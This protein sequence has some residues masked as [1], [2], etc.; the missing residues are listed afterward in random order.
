MLRR[1]EYAAP[2][3]RARFALGLVAG[4][5]LSGDTLPA[6]GVSVLVGIDL[7]PEAHD[8]ALRDRPRAYTEY[9]V[10]D[11][12]EPGLVAGLVEERGLNAPA[13]AG[14]LSHIPVEAFD[15]G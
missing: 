3:S 5:G 6:G 11:V 8:A 15:A 7:I 9:V 12:G 10:G 2:C 4:N 13:C 14:G 1:L